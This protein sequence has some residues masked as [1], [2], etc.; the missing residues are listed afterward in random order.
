MNDL[1]LCMFHRKDQA[2]KKIGRVLIPVLLL[3]VVGPVLAGPLAPPLTVTPVAGETTLF[4]AFAPGTPVAYVDW[5]VLSGGN[6][7]GSVLRPLVQQAFGSD[8]IPDGKYFYAYQVESLTNDAEVFT[9]NI[10]S[11]SLVE[12]AGASCLDL[13]DVGHNENY[14]SNLGSSPAPAEHEFCPQE[15]PVDST[16]TYLSQSCITWRF[17]GELDARE[18]SEALWFVSSCSPSYR[19][20]AIQQ[21]SVPPSP[22]TGGIPSNQVPAPG[23]VLL[24]MIGLGLINWTQRRLT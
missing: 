21:D 19:P 12:N 5:M 22:G 13:D 14:F 8:V 9:V 1:A 18:E 24:G 3:S 4:S 20:V 2:M 16:S 11:S 17:N 23:A 7:S 10:A 6:Y 15:P